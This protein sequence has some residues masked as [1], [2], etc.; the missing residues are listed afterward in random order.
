MKKEQVRYMTLSGVFCALVFVFTAYLHVPVHTGY[1]HMGDGL[2][3]VASCILPLPYGIFVGGIGALL[4]DALTGYAIWAPGSLII[5][6]ATVLMFSRKGEK[7]IS[8]RNILAL[9][10]AWILCIGGYYLYEG[11]ITGNFVAPAAGVVG[12]LI[13]CAFSTALFI[14]IATVFDRLKI[15]NKL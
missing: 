5:K 15:K 4:A 6:A 11:I 14:V 1:A 9:I 12:N 3:Y 8:V 10:P 13:Q 7:I 2:I